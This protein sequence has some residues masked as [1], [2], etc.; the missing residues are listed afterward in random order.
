MAFRNQKL[1]VSAQ[2]NDV[3]KRILTGL[4]RQEENRRCADCHARGPTW[5]SV[6]LGVFVC[7]NCSGDERID[8]GRDTWL[9][10]Q[11]A[12]V[13]AMGNAR[14]AG[15]WEANLPRPPDSDMGLLRTFITDK[16]VHRRYALQQSSEPPSIDNF[17]AHPVCV[18]VCVGGGG[19]ASSWWFLMHHKYPSNGIS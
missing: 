10:E 14:A 5:A 11:V 12:F 13:Q 9:P 6:N 7:L 18:D 2:Q 1:S 8:E 19:G 15:Y 3:H 16:Y 4:L 17:A